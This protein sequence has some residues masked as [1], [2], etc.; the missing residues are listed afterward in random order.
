MGGHLK[1]MRLKFGG[2]SQL[3]IGQIQTLLISLLDDERKSSKIPPQG[4][5]RGRVGQSSEGGVNG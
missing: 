4:G 5:D 2:Y 3:I 1:A